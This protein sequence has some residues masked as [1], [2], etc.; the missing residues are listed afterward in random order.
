MLGSFG[1]VAWGGFPAGLVG[2]LD[3]GCGGFMAFLVVAGCGSSGV[4]CGLPWV[5]G[6]WI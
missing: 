2:F 5:V 1:W 3:L 6:V 4:L